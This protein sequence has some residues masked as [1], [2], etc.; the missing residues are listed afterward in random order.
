M[1]YELI[2][3]LKKKRILA[4][5]RSHCRYLEHKSFRFGSFSLLVEFVYRLA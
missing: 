4:L 2:E 1:A 3:D 5:V